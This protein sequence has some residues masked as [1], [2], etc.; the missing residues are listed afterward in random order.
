MET[1]SL[2]MI[3]T[4]VWRVCET[5]NVEII[6]VLSVGPVALGPFSQNGNLSIRPVGVRGSSGTVEGGVD[7]GS[8]RGGGVGS[9]GGAAPGDEAVG[10]DEGG[11]VRTEAVGIGDLG[12]CT[13]GGEGDA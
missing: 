8:Q 11:A 9:G 4:F 7:G 10:P 1:M 6:G 5:G 13:V 3:L 12:G 2:R